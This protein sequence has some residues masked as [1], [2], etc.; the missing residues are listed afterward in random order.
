MNKP[1][2]PPASYAIAAGFGP[3]CVVVAARPDEIVSYASRDQKHIGY[4]AEDPKDDPEELRPLRRTRDT[5]SLA[6]CAIMAPTY[7]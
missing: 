4:F 2:Q 6:L 3:Y 7:V 1:A 5:L